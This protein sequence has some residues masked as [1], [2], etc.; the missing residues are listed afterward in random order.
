MSPIHPETAVSAEDFLPQRKSLP[1][2][3]AAVETCR[4]CDLYRNATQAVFGAGRRSAELVLVGEQ[5]GD[6]ED[7]AGAPFVGP[8][9]KLLDKALADAGIVRADVYV[10]NAVKHFKW[11]LRGKRRL[12]KKPSEREI[13]ACNPWLREELDLISPRAIAC[14][15]STAARAVFGEA[16]KIG[17]LRGR[18][19][20]SPYAARTLITVHPSSILRLRESTERADAFGR[21][22]ADLGLLAQAL[23][24]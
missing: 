2:L 10:T 18:F 15:G 7:L 17:E 13:A 9:G 14:L 1:S 5:P 8:A 16:L 4:G 20:P 23:I 19:L 12:H 6:A 3:R 11:E 21:F 24:K 22:V